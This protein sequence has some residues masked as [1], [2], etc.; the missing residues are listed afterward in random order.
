MK[1][2]AKER[3]IYDNYNPWDTYPD[4][5]LKEMALECEW[6]ENESEITEE[7]LCEWRFE[8]IEED[9]N[10]EKEMLS[11]FFEDKIVEFIG[12]V[13]LWHGTYEVKERDEFWKLF[14]KAMTDCDY[15][16]I[17][18]ENGHMY[19]TCSHHDGTNHFE[20][21]IVTEKGYTVL[22]RFA[23][24]VYGCPVREYEPITKEK[25]IDKLNNQAKSNYAGYFNG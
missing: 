25:L 8:Q 22:P 11:D 12:S 10:N 19:L 2:I 17:Y 7:N 1:K 23:E 5:V 6:V 16:K 21:K 15:F 14:D 13:G 4:D 18:D 9:W 3:T 20:I 24:K